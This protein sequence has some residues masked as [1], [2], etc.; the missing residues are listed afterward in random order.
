MDVVEQLLFWTFLVNLVNTDTGQQ[1]P[2]L[3]NSEGPDEKA[4]AAKVK[5]LLTTQLPPN[6]KPQ[7]MS[8]YMTQ[9]PKLG[10]KAS[11]PSLVLKQ[12][13]ED[14]IALGYKSAFTETWV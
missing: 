12:A 6:A 7:G 8:L 14:L 5:V 4:A 13:R 11:G 3:T 2:I 1:Q 9:N 10:P